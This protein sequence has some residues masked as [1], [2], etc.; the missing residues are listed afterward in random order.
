MLDNKVIVVTGASRGIGEAIARAAVDAVR[1]SC[2][3]SRKQ[4]DL[5]RGRELARGARARPSLPHRQ[6]RGGRRGDGRAVEKAGGVRRLGQQRRHQPYFG[7]MIDTPDAAIDKTFE[8]NVRGYLYERGPW[9]RHARGRA[10]GDRSS[11]SRVSPGSARRRCRASTA[12]QGRRDQ[13]DAD[14]RVRARRV[15]DPGQRDRPGPGRDEVR[16]GESSAPDAARPRRQTAR[17][18]R[19]TPSPRRSQVPRSTSVDARLVTD[20]FGGRRRRWSDLVLT[21]GHAQR[22]ASPAAIG[23][24]DR[25]IG[26]HGGGPRTRTSRYPASSR[27]NW[28]SASAGVSAA[29]SR[30]SAT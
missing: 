7:P 12:R 29:R 10:A 16:R 8:V 27:S 20:R 25:R 1:A 22:F 26:L 9:S 6:G 2:S 13:H 18:S 19:A 5:D 28:A 17:R 4:A 21:P 15:A 30:S 14:A 3:A 11:T 23:L 24:R